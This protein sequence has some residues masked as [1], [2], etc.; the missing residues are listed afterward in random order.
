[1]GGELWMKLEML[2]MSVSSKTMEGMERIRKSFQLADAQRTGTGFFNNGDRVESNWNED[3]E[4][5]YRVF[6]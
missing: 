6:A 2:A 1:M 4:F 3:L 5:S